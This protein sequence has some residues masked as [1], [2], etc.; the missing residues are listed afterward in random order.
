MRWQ[1]KKRKSNPE[2]QF[3]MRWLASKG[4]KISPDEYRRVEGKFSRKDLPPDDQR[5][6]DA[7]VELS[8]KHYGEF[9]AMRRQALKIKAQ[10][11]GR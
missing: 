2:W 10:R 5:I 11:L 9:C 7:I 3:S 4:L 6:V 1:K 8:L